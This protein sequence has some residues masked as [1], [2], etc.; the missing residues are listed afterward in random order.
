M[1]IVVGLLEASS[2]AVVI[3]DVSLEYCV[4]VVAREDAAKAISDD[5]DNDNMLLLV[6]DP[7]RLGLMLWEDIMGVFALDGLIEGLLVIGVLC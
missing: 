4:S 7:D 1:V 3:V 5:N 2:V 6:M